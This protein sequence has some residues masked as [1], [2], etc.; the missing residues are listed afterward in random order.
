MPAQ[1]ARPGGNAVPHEHPDAWQS[2]PNQA[3]AVNHYVRV[4]MIQ[5]ALQR[6]RDRIQA[7]GTTSDDPKK[8][9]REAARADARGKDCGCIAGKEIERDPMKA[10][11]P[12]TVA[13]GPGKAPGSVERRLKAALLDLRAAMWQEQDHPRD[14]AGRFARKDGGGGG[15]PAVEQTQE[16]SAHDV[17]YAMESMRL[18]LGVP[19]ADVP[20]E[21]AIA[22]LEHSKAERLKREAEEKAKRL[23]EEGD[24]DDPVVQA[25][26]DAIAV[27]QEVGSDEE[28]MAEWYPEYEAQA[29]ERERV[30]PLKEEPRSLRAA[31]QLRQKGRDKDGT[32]LAT[33]I[34]ALDRAVE[35]AWQK[36]P[37]FWRGTSTDELDSLLDDPTIG[38]LGAWDADAG[39]GD[40]PPY[41]FVPV[42]AAQAEA[43]AF[44]SGVVLEIDGDAVR[45]KEGAG[46]YRVRYD[47]F[48]YSNWEQIGG[49]EHEKADTRGTPYSS[50]L[51]H[52]L[53]TRIERGAMPAG[54]IRRIYVTVDPWTYKPGRLAAI[55]KKYEGI[56]P[57][58]F[59]PEGYHGSPRFGTP[60][61]TGKV[62]AA[63]LAASPAPQGPER[64]ALE[65][66]RR[67][68]AHRRKWGLPPID[69][70]RAAESILRKWRPDLAPPRAALGASFEESEHPRDDDGKFT[71]KEGGGGRH[72][73]ADAVDRPSIDGSGARI[74]ALRQEQL[75]NIGA[76][77]AA[78][79][80]G[81][82]L[83]SKV[84]AAARAALLKA[85]DRGTYGQ[86]PSKDD[87]EKYEA[88]L[89]G[90][91]EGWSDDRLANAASELAER[92]STLSGVHPALAADLAPLEDARRAARQAANDAEL[93]AARTAYDEAPSFWRGTNSIREALTLAEVGEWGSGY[94]DG[95]RR[96]LF[97]CFSADSHTAASFG[98]DVIFEVYGSAMRRI[99]N[100]DN[101]AGSPASRAPRT[102]LPLNWERPW[103]AIRQHLASHFESRVAHGTT[104]EDLPLRAIH[105]R[106]SALRD[107][108][109][110][111]PGTND[112]DDDDDPLPDHDYESALAELSRIAPVYVHKYTRLKEMDATGAQKEG[113]RQ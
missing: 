89:D 73:V 36:A 17:D 52:E 27:A 66:A 42:S 34:A 109:G 55:A 5:R 59:V 103:P 57:V 61:G 88:F 76:A 30:A 11:R 40:K 33:G 85:E 37:S 91:T 96:G 94:K 35:E 1:I 3:R 46:A 64:T 95:D 10:M 106:E 32:L 12:I 14:E 38:S 81:A 29:A 44:G 7:S 108:V 45:R 104:I 31:R 25:A 24:P 86:Y 26:R 99:A 111:D 87:L 47:P 48:A 9:E 90:R 18:Y 62:K 51:Q 78:T 84:S 71:D 67:I 28:A 82:D 77:F 54:A 16:W 65:A 60:D 15:T 113:A 56:A 53:E 21:K 4:S 58:Q 72:A 75:D 39:D 8:S 102:R 107:F 110:E 41:A 13:V 69:V 63:A 93:D 105:V 68:A 43:A 97:T 23:E 100:T 50:A 112:D 83:P 92:A 2:D 20:R 22:Y 80:R 98:A 49:R 6:W 74:A 79:I 70:G 101:D 19:K